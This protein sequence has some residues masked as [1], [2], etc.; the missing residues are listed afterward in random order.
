MSGL[1]QTELIRF[2][3]MKQLKNNSKDL[4]GFPS[5]SRLKILSYIF[6][7]LHNYYNIYGIFKQNYSFRS[8]SK[9]A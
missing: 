8:K 5:K 4:K 2:N 9:S 6:F 7:L 3:K 1:N